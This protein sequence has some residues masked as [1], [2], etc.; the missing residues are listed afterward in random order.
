MFQPSTGS[1]SGTNE[2]KTISVFTT[3]FL[4]QYLPRIH[5]LKPR[6]FIQ[7]RMLAKQAKLAKGIKKK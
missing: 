7:G 4:K 2:L 3:M 5:R 1:S 6:F